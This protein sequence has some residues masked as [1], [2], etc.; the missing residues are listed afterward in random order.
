MAY[1]W[2][3]AKKAMDNIIGAKEEW[4]IA[5]NVKSADSNKRMKEAENKARKYYNEL[6]QNGYGTVASNLQ[7][8]NLTDSKKYADVYYTK[9]GR[10]SFRPY[11][12]EKGKQYNLSQEDVDKLITYDS[13]T[14]E[15]IFAGKNIGKPD[16]VVDGSSYYKPEYLETVWSNYVTDNGINRTNDQLAG[17]N[18]EGVINKINKAFNIQQDDRDVM[19]QKTGRLEDYN[20]EHNP[21]ESEIGKSIMNKYKYLGDNASGDAVADGAASNSGNVDSFS[22]ANAARQQLAFTTAGQEAVLADFNSRVANARGILSDLG[23]FLQNNQDNMYRTTALQ[24]NEAQRLAENAE[25]KKL[26]EQQI[27]SNKYDNW[28]KEAEITGYVPVA[29]A[30]RYNPYL[31]EDG[32]LKDASIDYNARLTQLENQLNN[33]TNPDRKAA[34]EQNIRWNNDARAAKV[35]LPEYK[36]YAGDRPVIYSG[37][38]ESANMKLTKAQIQNALD[39]A[40]MGNESAER[41]NTENVNAQ[42]QMNADN[43]RSER[44]KASKTPIDPSDLVP[45]ISIDDSKWSDSTLDNEIKNEN[46]GGYKTGEYGLDY[47]GVKLIKGLRSRISKEFGGIV[48]WS[49]DDEVNQFLNMV[50]DESTK[51]HVEIGQLQKVFNYLGISITASDWFEDREEDYTKKDNS[52]SWSN[53]VKKIGTYTSDKQDDSK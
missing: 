10:S 23:V 35:Q 1:T 47:Y 4:Q 52:A 48:D 45:Y 6:S 15:V 13:D 17:A 22:A 32:T 42:M 53:G 49:N 33:E 7:S 50:E 12:S 41:I 43:N 39:L 34:I 28:M 3:Q 16:G 18:S 40:K 2:E 27:E 29:L 46:G 31:N 8:K 25:A 44:Y 51:A 14:G 20:Y 36:Q 30:N 24:Q 19:L 38:Q 37:S 26:N 9:T 5:N 21:Y 11:M